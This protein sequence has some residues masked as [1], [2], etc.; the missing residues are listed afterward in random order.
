MYHIL[1]G[2]WHL[3]QNGL[4]KCWQAR[5][6]VRSH[7]LIT[8]IDDMW[9][10][11]SQKRFLCDLFKSNVRDFGRGWGWGLGGREGGGGGLGVGLGIGL[12]PGGRGVGVLLIGQA[13][14][15]AFDKPPRTLHSCNE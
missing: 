1:K 15:L 13:S 2:F 4:V 8:L 6:F 11:K 5:C 3:Y 9:S 12:E 7:S 14:S 10:Q